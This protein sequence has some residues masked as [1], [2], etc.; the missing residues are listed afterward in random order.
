[1]PGAKWFEGAQ[2]NY[3]RA[4]VSPCGQ[5]PWRRLCGRHQPQRKGRAP[6]A[7]LART[8]APGRCLGA[9][10]AAARRAARRPRGGVPAEHP[11]S[12]RRLPGGGEHRRRLEPLRARHGHQRR[13]GPLQADRAQGADRL[14]RRHLRRPR[15]RPHRRRGRAARRAADRHASGRASQSR[16]GRCSDAGA[17]PHGPT[18]RRS[19][20]ATAMPFRRSSRCGCPS[21]IRCGSS[22]PAAPRACPSPSSTAM[23]VP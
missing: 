4:G 13:A 5:G 9:A 19:R 23:A 20:P 22:T 6:R 15:L 10:S 7:E 12:H 21:T 2:F 3:V 14:R 16:C 11:G 1:M 8:A 18:W 17:G